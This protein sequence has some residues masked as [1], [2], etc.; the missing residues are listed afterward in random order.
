[1]H[2]IDDNG[3]GFDVT[4]VEAKRNSES[5]M[6]LFIHEGKNSIQRTRICALHR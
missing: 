1:M 5:G 6:G 2:C 4:Q 3:K